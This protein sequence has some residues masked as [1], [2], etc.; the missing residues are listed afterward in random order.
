LLTFFVDD[1]GSWEAGWNTFAGLNEYQAWQKPSIELALDIRSSAYWKTHSELQER[2]GQ[3]EELRQEHAVLTKARDN[4]TE[5]FPRRPWF[6]DGIAF[7]K[8]LKE[9]ETQNSG[10]ANPQ[11]N[12]RP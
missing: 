12:P 10:L 6:V 1:D 4:L 9:L 5:L 8:K 7:R 2:R 11:D 3:A